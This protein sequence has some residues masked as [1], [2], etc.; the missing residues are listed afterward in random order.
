MRDVYYKSG[1]G[2]LIV[3]AVNDKSSLDDVRERFRSLLNS[4]VSS[5]VC[6]EATVNPVWR[7]PVSK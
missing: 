6:P 1:H 2:F 3:Y 5:R 4:R 7:T